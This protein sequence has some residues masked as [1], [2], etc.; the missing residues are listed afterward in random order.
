ME[1]RVAIKLNANRKVI[2]TLRG[3]D[4]FMNLVLENSDEVVS[5]TEVVRMGMV[6]I[7]GSSIL[8]IELLEG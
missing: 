3:F 1:R 6:V 2:G 7:R 4:P 8:N 5:D